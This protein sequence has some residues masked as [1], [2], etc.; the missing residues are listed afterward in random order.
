MPRPR[1]RRPPQCAEDTFFLLLSPVEASMSRAPLW[2][3]LA[4]FAVIATSLFLAFSTEP[5]LGLDLR[6][7]TQLVFETK[8]SPTVKADSEATDRALDVLRRRADALGVV[9]P[10]LVRSGEKRIIVELPGVLDPQQAAEVIGRTA[11]LAFHSVEGLGE[12]GDKSA[13][14]DESGQLLKLSP[15]V[16]SGDGITDAAAESDPQR[17]PGWWV[18]VQFR[19]VGAWQKMTGE[20]ACAPAGDPK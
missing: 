16:I 9:D 1:G 8:D 5:R 18:S 14:P 11:Q 17:G 10:T 13:L 4:A 15:P 20:A 6:G 3:A 19:D 2:R 12:K 7:G